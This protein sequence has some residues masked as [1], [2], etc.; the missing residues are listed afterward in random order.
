MIVFVAAIREIL[1]KEIYR[2]DKD[3]FCALKTREKRT[4]GRQL[5]SKILNAPNRIYE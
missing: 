5:E 2:R 1:R 3:C 4:R